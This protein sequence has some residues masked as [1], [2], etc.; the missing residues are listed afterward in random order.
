MTD[1]RDLT[2]G[3][4]RWLALAD[5][6]TPAKSLAR[7][8]TVS[9]R[10]VS[11]VGVVATLLTGFGLLAATLPGTGGVVR[12]VAIGSVVLAV[13]AVA[14]AVAA[15]VVTITTDLNPTDLLEVEA[16]YRTRFA[17]RAPLTRGAGLLLLLSVVAAGVVAI[18]ALLDRGSHAP[19]LALT[20][21]AELSSGVAPAAAPSTVT[22]QV[23]FSDLAADETVLVTVTVAGDVAAQ[24]ALTPRADGT[25]ER[26][27][28]V[29]HV[30]PG[31][32]VL[33]RAGSSD[34][35]CSGT[36]SP[37]RPARVSC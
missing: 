37:R 20:R 6:L 2:P 10:V 7:L 13:A 1:S 17:S 29:A 35:S 18:T 16:W 19:V 15:Q 4:R 24:A 36:L 32:V 33:V 12:V 22:V 27:L 9:A 30:A 21:T 31:A 11:T 5:E 28:T 3:E 8:D 26:S 25:V 34:E 23:R 14:C